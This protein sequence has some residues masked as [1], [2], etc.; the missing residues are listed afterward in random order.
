[1]PSNRT[2]PQ[3]GVADLARR[4]HREGRERRLAP[5]ALRGERRDGRPLWR[6]HPRLGLAARR[7]PQEPGAAVRAQQPRA[8]GRQGRADRGRGHAPDRARRVRARGHGR[9]FADTV[10]AMV[11][12]ASSR[13]CRSASCR[14]ASP[15]PIFDA[16]KHLTGF[17]YIAQELLELSVVHGA[18]QS[19]RAAARQDASPCQASKCA[20]L[21][22]DGDCRPRRSRGAHPHH[23]SFPPR[24]ASGGPHPRT[25]S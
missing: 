18:R 8:A 10:W 20:A 24:Q 2:A 5:R 25:G 9:P 14:S 15:N 13:R 23:H 16:D 11:D 7:L 3:V 17:E 6:H 4:H 1:M 22:D 12:R 21:F 19:E